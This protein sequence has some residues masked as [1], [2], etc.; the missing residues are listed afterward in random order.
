MKE[1][2]ERFFSLKENETTVRTEAVGGLTTFLTMAYIIVVN[3]LI[4]SAVGFPFA[5]VLFATVLVA[6][7]SSIF[8]G[9]YANLPAAL[10][11][12]MGLNAFVA[13]GMVGAMGLSWQTA[14]AAVFVS[15][16]IFLVL[17]L[18][19]ARKK[20]VKAIPQSLRKGVAAGIGLFLAFIGLQSTGLL[21]TSEETLLTFGGV[22][23]QALIFLFGLVLTAYFMVKKIRG[24]LVFGI[25]GTTA[26][27]WALSG[28]GLAE[29]AEFSGFFAMPSASAL[30]AMDMSGL[31]TVAIIAPLFTLLF[32][33]MFDSISTFVGLANVSGLVDEEGEPKNV[34]RALVVDSASTIMSGLFGSSPGT[35]YIE[36]ASGIREGG[37]TGL[38]A[39]VA[40]LLFL[41]FMFLSPLLSL[42]PAIAT[43]PVL[44]IVGLY[45]LTTL[46]DMDWHDYSESIPAFLA[47]IL[48]PLTY[49]IT[50]GIASSFIAYTLIRLVVTR[51]LRTIPLTL[52]IIAALSVVLLFLV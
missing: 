8:M 44:V 37:R 22:S 12:G 7:L 38:T 2:L 20:I 48:I 19:G 25:L 40:G 16:I 27:S 47:L 23:M 28:F 33:D 32:T 26:V 3:P 42:I 45:M 13:F 51:S 14:L 35:V 31:L 9:M 21:I 36:S 15:G 6:S 17:S 49:S 34:Q 10:A 11:P 18:I 1:W 43:A 46:S 5:G 4:L 52:W 24:A 30:L 29:V 50:V 41:P 39:V